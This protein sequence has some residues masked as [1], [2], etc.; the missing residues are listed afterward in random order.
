MRILTYII[1]TLLACSLLLNVLFIF[2]G[3]R[4]KGL[5]HE[6]TEKQTQNVRMHEEEDLFKPRSHAKDIKSKALKK[7]LTKIQREKSL[8]VSNFE[9]GNV[10]Y[11]HTTNVKYTSSNKCTPYRPCLRI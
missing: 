3:V 1:G 11:V 2:Q 8:R 4:S 10:P 9:V 7:H 6:Q 5:S